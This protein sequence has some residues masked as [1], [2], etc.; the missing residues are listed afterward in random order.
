M[1]EEHPMFLCLN[2]TPGK[3]GTRIPKWKYDL[4]RHAILKVVP[5]NDEGITFKELPSLI[6][7]TLT[8]LD[9]HRL[10][11]VSWYTT[12]VKLDLEVRGEIE[13]IPGMRPQRLR[14]LT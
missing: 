3:H 10:G 4:I 11:S 13:R 7:K 12:T 6:E 5:K 1:A 14:R 8:E 2:P 9:Q